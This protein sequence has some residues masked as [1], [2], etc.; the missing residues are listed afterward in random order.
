MSFTRVE[1][2]G[3]VYAENDNGSLAIVAAEQVVLNIHRDNN[4]VP[5]AFDAVFKTSAYTGFG[6]VPMNVSVVS[7][8]DIEPAVIGEVLTVLTPV[9]MGEYVQNQVFGIP[10]VIAEEVV[11]E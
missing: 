11:S 2:D 10:Q 7:S 9:W 1:K 8:H 6:S 3:K 5:I 4:G